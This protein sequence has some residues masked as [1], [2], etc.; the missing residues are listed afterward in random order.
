ML[1]FAQDYL[2]AAPLTTPCKRQTSSKRRA[3]G[4]QAGR[5]W[6]KL[7]RMLSSS[8]RAHQNPR[9][10][11][12]DSPWFSSNRL[13]IWLPILA[14]LLAFGIAT[15]QL[16]QDSMWDDEAW[17]MWAIGGSAAE[18]WQ[19]VAADVHPPLYF[20]LL[21]R[22]AA[23]LGETRYVVRLLSTLFGML[24]L[25][26]TCA[27]G[28]E[29]FDAWVGGIAA[30]LLGT[31]GFFI[32]YTSEV[33]M[34][35]LLLCLAAWST[36]VYL[37]WLRQG[38]PA[39]LV[40]YALTL[41]A[42]PYTHYYGALIP[43]TQLLHLLLTRPRRLKAWLVAAGLALALYAPWLPILWRQI[44]THPDG[45]LTLPIPTNW[46][47]LG[48]LLKVLSGG[49]GALFLLPFL[50]GRALPRVR[51][52]RD[53][54]LLLLLWALVTPL[55]ILALNAWLAS[56][57]EMRYVIAVLPAVAL[58]AA[59]GLRHV[60][61]RPLALG[62]TLWIVYTSLALYRPFWPPRTPW[63]TT[64][65]I[66][67]IAARQPGEPSL[68]MI[69]DPHGL[70]AHLEQHVGLRNEASIDLSGRRRSPAEVQALVANLDAEPSVWLVLPSNVGET[71][72]AAAALDEQRHVAY[73][74]NAAQVLF[75][76][77]DQG[78]LD[79]LQ[80]RFGDALRYTGSL[81]ADQPPLQAGEQFCP[82]ITLT[83]LTAL[84]A[85]Y[86]L[87]IHL[88]NAANVLVA[89][90]DAGLGARAAGEQIQLAPCL[91]VPADVAPGDY[92]VHLLVYTWADGQRLP[93]L[94]GGAAS[95]HWGDRLVL[96]AVSVD[97][98]QMDAD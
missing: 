37:R 16:E 11:L 10:H 33:R 8:H 87:G 7:L 48:W 38:A 77:F 73:R 68:V 61:W 76:R 30:L 34:Y 86:S 65:A 1:V 27:I 2:T 57:Y 4:K 44:Q 93:L 55:V 83:A 89:Q 25:A 75:Y 24:G 51:Q 66:Q 36:W 91:N 42:L 79:D 63:G 60:F 69:V 88:V 81:F 22:W 23:L 71:W 40:V 67:A 95:V 72:V 78:D 20:V 13:L 21:D 97:G 32:H 74:D 39:R 5:F 49:S 80:F 18:T 43:L 41:A 29:L 70:E 53:A 17:S 3:C 47:T 35:T 6:R 62:L 19:R 52:Y 64:A 56:L 31:S 94:E 46:E 58:L 82:R 84:D 12:L 28:K 54:I 9:I 96:G 14:I 59:L 92:Y 45:P 50:T 26:L 15:S 98:T 85:S 90:H